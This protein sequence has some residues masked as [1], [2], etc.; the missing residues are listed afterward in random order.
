MPSPLVLI[1]SKR[2]PWLNHDAPWI[3]R[4]TA[5]DLASLKS[6]TVDVLYWALQLTKERKATLDNPAG[7][8]IAR[9]RSPDLREV[10]QFT[11]AKTEAERVAKLRLVRAAQEQQ[12]IQRLSRAE[13]IS[14]RDNAARAHT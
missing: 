12:P 11:N 5:E 10:R 7:F 9:M 13:M 14:I 4:R 8:F 6:T 1:L 2:P 3:D